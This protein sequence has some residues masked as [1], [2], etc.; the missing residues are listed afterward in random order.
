MTF[1]HQHVNP[2]ISE[3][4]YN[5]EEKDRDIT[6]HDLKFYNKA[7]ATETIQAQKRIDIKPNGTKWNNQKQH[8]TANSVLTKTTETYSGG[9]MFPKNGSEKD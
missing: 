1:L 5:P 2:K 3:I 8:A 7:T 4:Q 6:I 9:K